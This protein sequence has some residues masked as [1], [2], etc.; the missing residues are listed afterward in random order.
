MAILSI[1]L[2]NCQIVGGKKGN[3]FLSAGWDLSESPWWTGANPGPGHSSDSHGCARIHWLYWEIVE[4]VNWTIYW[5]PF[6]IFV[7]MSHSLSWV[8]VEHWERSHGDHFSVCVVKSHPLH[9]HTRAVIGTN[10]RSQLQAG[11]QFHNY[12]DK[13]NY[14]ICCVP[15]SSCVPRAQFHVLCTVDT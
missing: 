1:K 14:W 9:A 8:V 10:R 5:I 7:F 4:L 12:C 13:F 15:F 3:L 11:L 2:P 6:P